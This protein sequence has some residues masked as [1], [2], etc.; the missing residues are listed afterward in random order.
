MTFPLPV[1][2][3]SLLDELQPR[4]RPPGPLDMGDARVQALLA[5]I[6]GNILKGQ[7]RE[8]SSFRFVRFE[9]PEAALRWLGDVGGAMTTETK[10]REQARRFRAR[11]AS[12]AKGE[13]AAYSEEDVFVGLYLTH[14]GMAHIGMTAV[15]PFEPASPTDPRSHRMSDAYRTGLLNP[16]HKVVGGRAQRMLDD[17][18]SW[19]D[20]YEQELHALLVVSFDAQ[21]RTF[22]EA[23]LR[24]WLTAPGV[25]IRD[26][27]GKPLPAEEGARIFAANGTGTRHEIEHFGF[28]DGLSNP[29]FLAQE[30]A[31]EH[32][33]ETPLF[34]LRHVLLP[35]RSSP[36]A[37]AAESFGSF[38]VFRKLEQ[39]VKLFRDEIAQ[40]STTL[41]PHVPDAASAQ[42]KTGAWVVGRFR[43]GTP[44]TAFADPAD[45]PNHVFSYAQDADGGRC[46]FHAHIRKM[47]FRPSDNWAAQSGQHLPVRRSI[48]YG[49]RIF[50]DPARRIVDPSDTPEKGVGLLLMAFVASIEDQFE[51]LMQKWANRGGFPDPKAGPDPL[52]AATREGYVNIDGPVVAGR[53][54][55]RGKLA[56]C[57]HPRGGAYLFAPPRSFFTRLGAPGA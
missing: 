12:V 23:M 35:L 52:I 37:P 10:A 27:A 1:A 38:V 43:D 44:L 46:P 49:K 17:A 3:S 9:L 2:K 20:G 40:L 42:E 25:S 45:R 15:I 51:K 7:A 26:A 24:H 22:A 31:A 14:A 54:Q 47:N 57:V 55:T 21:T 5:D 8:F 39:N 32:G 33:G 29:R 53:P 4:D 34:P 11:Q 13:V 16:D 19:D 36:G 50:T 56:Q 41:F 18:D 48:A 30:D 28:A 6:P